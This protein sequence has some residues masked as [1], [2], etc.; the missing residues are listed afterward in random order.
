MEKKVLRGSP[1]GK[2]IHE[3]MIIISHKESENQNYIGIPSH[4]VRVAIIKK[5]DNNKF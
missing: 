5:T 2:Y 3:E 4:P 1:N